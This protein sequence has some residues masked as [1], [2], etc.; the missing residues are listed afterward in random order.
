MSPYRVLVVDDSAMDRKLA[1][2]LLE[3]Q[4]DFDVG[5]AN[6]GRE[7]LESIRKSPPDAILSDLQMP[8]I[9]GL[10]LVEMVRSDFPS[11]PV[12]LMT[13][14]GSEEIA[15]EALR[16]GAASY[17]PKTALPQHLCG[18]LRQILDAVEADRHKSR[19]MHSLQQSF[20]VFCLDNDPELFDLAML[21][22]QQLLRCLPLADEAERLRVC[23]AVKGALEIC[24]HH[25]NF[26]IPL[27]TTLSDDAFA[28]LAQQRGN[29][30]PYCTRSIRLECDIHR[31]QARFVITHE[32]PGIDWDRL[33]DDP[34]DQATE[35]SWLG[36]FLM[37]RAVMDECLRQPNG[38]TLLKRAATTSD[39][40]DFDLEDST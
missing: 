11:I 6:N 13:A 38:I 25:G 34:G 22:I 37:L 10:Q 8:E 27:D 1:G 14:R 17:V 39:E 29:T 24:H 28:E 33:P 20:Q 16:R 26:E 4:D 23:V 2:R 7:A 9:N 12:V 5:F 35:H 18:T 19:L 31:D 32:G 36:G 3:T 40:N 30:P 15:A 21:E